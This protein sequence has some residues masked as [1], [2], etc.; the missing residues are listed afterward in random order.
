MDDLPDRF[1]HAYWAVVHHL[2]ALRLRAWEE[3]GLTLAQLRV[4]FLLR[5]SPG[6][7]T[8][9]LASEMGV[10][11]P[12]V[13]GLVDK[14]ARA[15]LVE[16][17]QR[18]DDRRVVPLRLTSEGAAV[19]GE[20]RHGNRAYLAGIAERLGPE[21]EPI[22]EALEQLAGVIE[23]QDEEPGGGEDKDKKDKEDRNGGE[24]APRLHEQRA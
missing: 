15:G 3:H 10:T 20:I 21:L 9:M 24:E 19:V 11:M 1:R 7:T 4:L 13:S 6:A 23:S 22:T 5:A 17:C 18:A 14:L 12:T 8:N 2:D 16:R